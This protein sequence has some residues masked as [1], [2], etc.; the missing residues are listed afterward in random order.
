MVELDID[1]R[2]IA[3]KAGVED[4]DGGPD[5]GVGPEFIDG[6][7]GLVRHTLDGAADLCSHRGGR[8]CP[9]GLKGCPHG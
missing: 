5:L 7:A 6:I 9:A 4:Y 2:A 3:E 8:L 1:Y